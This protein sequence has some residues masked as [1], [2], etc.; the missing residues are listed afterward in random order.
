MEAGVALPSWKGFLEMVEN[1]VVGQVKFFSVARRA[2]SKLKSRDRYA[3][4][5]DDFLC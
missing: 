1:K 2:W 5:G 3:N 4:I